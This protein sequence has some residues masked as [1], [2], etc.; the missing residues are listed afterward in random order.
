MPLVPSD[1]EN[2]KTGVSSALQ[3]VHVSMPGQ[4]QTYYPD[5]Q[6]ADIQPMVQEV[7][8]T[9]DGNRS[10]FTF[11]VLPNVPI[12]FPRGGGFSMRFP[13]VQGDS[14]LLVFLESS[15]SEWRATGQISEPLDLRR[16]GLGSPVAYPGL[17]P[18]TAPLAGGDDG[19]MRMG[20][21]G[22]N[23]VF[24]ATENELHVGKGASSYIALADKVDS[25]ISK[26]DNVIRTAWI[27][28]PNDGG[29]ALKAAYINTTAFPS[30][31]GSVAATISKAL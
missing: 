2:I 13:L 24:E 22:A 12:A 18:D 3:G 11:P 31:P 19:V 25:F 5:T 4:V 9:E 16:H 14:V 7:L 28:A 21:D 26:L 20:M 30:A 10:A 27:V 6:T 29:A 15:I 1:S 17:A 8:F 23:Q